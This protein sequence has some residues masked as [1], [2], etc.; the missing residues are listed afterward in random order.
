MALPLDYTQGS[1]EDF[2][3]RF[4]GSV[5]K[6]GEVP[7]LITGLAPS[8]TTTRFAVQLLEL[9][10][11]AYQ[12]HTYAPD[13]KSLFCDNLGQRLGFASAPGPNAI[14]YFSRI[15]IR[16]MQQGLSAGNLAIA[17]INDAG[18]AGIGR[19]RGAFFTE[20]TEAIVYKHWRPSVDG[21]YQ[22]RAEAISRH[23]SG[24]SGETVYALASTGFHAMF[25]GSYPSIPAALECKR[26]RVAI[27]REFYLEKDKD[28][29]YL[30]TYVLGSVRQRIGT[31][32]KERVVLFDKYKFYNGL[33]KR[34]LDFSVT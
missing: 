33:V 26:T 3:R 29:A 28:N 2:R 11:D 9:S 25:T 19:N 21:P 30:C 24:A 16:G 31:V 14:L 12:P 6:C 18:V 15:P 20:G 7:A 23:F 13:H 17:V 34:S 27:S 1:S 10:E 32:N 22:G 8:R 5:I 4:L